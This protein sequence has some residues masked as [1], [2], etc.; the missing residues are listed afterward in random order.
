MHAKIQYL[1]H[2]T[3]I[4]NLTGIVGN[5]LFS[6]NIAH[7]QMGPVDISMSEVNRH[8][9]KSEPVY[10]KSL[11]EYVPL[12]FNP[13]NPMLYKLKNISSN[14]AIIAFDRDLIL[15]SEVVFT[16]GNA[17][18]KTT[19][20]Y[21]DI[22]QLKKMDWDFMWAEYC[23]DYIGGKRRQCAEVLVP[24][25]IPAEYIKKI[26]VEGYESLQKVNA[27]V[28]SQVKCVIDEGLFSWRSK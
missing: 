20:F 28:K 7:E 24:E 2:I 22:R 9:V 8:R 26:S 4:D 10:R 25:K 23:G 12:Y 14:I 5:G 15:H 3:H 11:H 1:F 6:H 21:S 18:T 19:R 16:E 17:A 27:S 13:R